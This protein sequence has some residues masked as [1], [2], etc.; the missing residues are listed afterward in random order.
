MCGIVGII[1]FQ[2][3]E[4]NQAQHI[5]RMADSITHRGPDDDG[6]IL[7]AQGRYALFIGDDTPEITD[8]ALRHKHIASSQTN[9]SM[10][11]GHRRLSILDLSFAGH[12]PMGYLDRY[13]IVYNGEIYNYIEI[14]KELEQKGYSFNSTSDTEMIMAAYDHWGVKCLDKFNGMWAFVL[15]DT[16]ADKI[17]ISRDRFSI[18]P[19]YYYKDDKRFIFASEVK[20]IMQHPEVKTAPNLHYCRNY[21]KFGPQE[22]IKET[23]FENIFHFMHTSYLEIDLEKLGS[24]EIQE[25][26]YWQSKPNL[27][28]EKFDQTKA[29]TYA[30][31]Y[32][33]I[34]SDAVRLRLRADVKVGAALSG[35]LDSS[36][37]AYMI[38]QHL[39]EQGQEEKLETFSSVYKSSDAV[40]DCD[41]S[42]FVD[43]LSVFLNVKSNQ[44]EPKTSELISE[45]GEMIY[46][47][48]NP[49]VG[50]NMGGWYTF[51]LVGSTDVTINL[52]GQGADEQL[53]GYYSYLWRYFANIS[54]SDVISEYFAFSQIPGVK[55]SKILVSILFNILQRILPQK[56]MQLF[57]GRIGAKYNLSITA[58]VNTM[59]LESVMTGLVNLIHFGDSQ[60]MAHSIESRL[61][62]MDYRLVE[63]LASVPA[64][65]K[66][67]NGWTKYLARLAMDKKL[68]DNITWRKDKMGWP[69]PAEYWFRGEFKE[70]L[71]SEVEFS[72]FMQE[73]GVGA[74]IRKRIEGKEP[75]INLIRLLNLSVW[76]KMF[77]T[78]K[79]F[80]E[81]IC[82]ENCCK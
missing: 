29:D 31:E 18:K 22:Y 40:R 52:D 53:G 38:N 81:N 55:K 26:K 82:T 39:K 63:Y 74:D 66:I 12:Q 51:K 56:I 45:H 80:Q 50:P 2:A 11:L 13:W 25:K 70:W 35:G 75:I 36:T 15:Y 32:Y 1:N 60:S 10:A 33:E 37:I 3:K 67:H 16:Q 61:P 68:P 7:C 72:P 77:F 47:M 21:I 69:D 57:S 20:A 65:Y 28:N 8:D 54:L 30:K 49:A 6:Y 42:S 19:L 44:T 59:L 78:D 48:E 24:S 76:Y 34:L 27:S 14:K 4:T 9:S 64:A 41:E 73:L 58:P 62:F 17:F 46:A 79:I 23:A 5:R 43:E 71:C